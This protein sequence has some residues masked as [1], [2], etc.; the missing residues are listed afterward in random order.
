MGKRHSG[1][2]VA[3]VRV[4]SV[5]RGPVARTMT[6]WVSVVVPCEPRAVTVWVNEGEQRVVTVA[7]GRVVVVLVDEALGKV[8][9]GP[10]AETVRVKVLT[11]VAEGDKLIKI[12]HFPVDM[13]A[14]GI[15]LRDV[16]VDLLRNSCHSVPFRD[17]NIT[18]VARACARTRVLPT[19]WSSDRGCDLVIPAIS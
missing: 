10:R 17:L 12:C 11:T 9:E 16:S 5:S 4:V 8:T 13:R 18:I 1:V 15:S 6:C 3:V 7:W 19:V 2:T 14:Y